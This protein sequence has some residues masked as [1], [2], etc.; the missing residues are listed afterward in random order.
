MVNT[1]FETKDEQMKTLQRMP[2]C[3][4]RNIKQGLLFTVLLN[5][6]KNKHFGAVTLNAPQKSNTVIPFCPGLHSS[7]AAAVGAW[8]LVCLRFSS[9]WK[10]LVWRYL[11]CFAFVSILAFFGSTERNNFV[12]RMRALSTSISSY[13]QFYL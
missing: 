10:R 12:C 3:T 8:Q 9:S 2:R 5:K 6:L 11:S 13:L 4:H 7:H 1:N